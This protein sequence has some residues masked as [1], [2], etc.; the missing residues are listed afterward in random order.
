MNEKRHA[1]VGCL[2]PLGIRKQ[3]QMAK[4]QLSQSIKDKQSLKRM[5]NEARNQQ[6]L[7]QKL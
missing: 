3:M 4:Y 6:R 7:Q 1:S 2:S 5:R